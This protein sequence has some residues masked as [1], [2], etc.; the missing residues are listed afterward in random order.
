[1]RATALIFLCACGA[2]PKLSPE[3][4]ADVAGLDAGA[5]DGGL[6]A[7]VTCE[8][9][10]FSDASVTYAH[11]DLS[12]FGGAVNKV[13]LSSG[14]RRLQVELWWKGMNE[15]ATFPWPVML[16]P[17]HHSEC[18]TCVVLREGCVGAACTTS[19][20]AIGGQLEFTEATRDWHVG[21]F[22]GSAGVLRLVEWST[23][24]DDALPNGRCF[25]VTGVAFDAG[26]DLADAGP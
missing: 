9:L 8:Q 19:S 18:D 13:E 23:R 4:V 21:R 7:G 14:T 3:G 16:W 6:D 5:D 10:D 11:Y 15:Q 17:T 26:W 1:M 12:L 22:A 25:E 24:D 2:L 20:L